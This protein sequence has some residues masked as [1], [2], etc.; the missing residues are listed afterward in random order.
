MIEL[1]EIEQ[2]LIKNSIKKRIILPEG[3]SE[4]IIDTANYLQKNNIAKPI[5]IFKSETEVSSKL[6]ANCEIICIDKY[7][8]NYLANELYSL[9]KGKLS[10]E[11]AQ[12]L[13][14]QPN[15]FATMLLKLN[16]ADCMLCGITYTTADVIR[17]ALQIIKTNAKTK[18]A[19]STMIMKK[20][21]GTYLFSDCSLNLDPN[22]EELVD[23]A[24]L[25]I[26]FAKKMKMDK[27]ELA[28]LSYSTNSSGAGPDVDKIK[29]TMKIMDSENLP[30]VYDGETQFDAAFLKDIRNKKYRNSKLT[31]EHPDIYIFPNLNAG[32]ISYKIAEYM[33]GYDAIGPFIMGLNKPVNDLSRGANLKDIISTSLITIFQAFEI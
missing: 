3:D 17:P 1:K 19:A 29:M 14:K 15:Y 2:F 22:S 8:L 18:I 26:E 32:N 12:E 9:R 30:F 7:D 10:L 31:K 23:I 21:D 28:F 25:N 5:V 16:F 33:G 4:K 6:M 11:E 20:N 24:K 13:V 27:P